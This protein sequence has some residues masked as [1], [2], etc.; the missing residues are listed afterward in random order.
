VRR[1]RVG[2]VSWIVTVAAR[3]CRAEELLGHQEVM[4]LTVHAGLYPG[5]RSQRGTG[6]VP[7]AGWAAAGVFGSGQRAP[8]D[9]AAVLGKAD[10]R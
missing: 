6:Y 1:S 7:G 4:P 8:L 2:V 9:V 3:Q 5:D 10:R